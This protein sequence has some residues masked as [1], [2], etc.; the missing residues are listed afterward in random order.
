MFKQ[1][2]PEMPEKVPQDRVSQPRKR[3]PLGRLAGNGLDADRPRPQKAF[4][5]ALMARRRT[6]P[7]SDTQ[8]ATAGGET[9]PGVSL[10]TIDNR[11]TYVLRGATDSLLLQRTSCR[12]ADVHLLQTFHFCKVEAFDLWCE[13]DLLRFEEPHLWTQLLRAGH[14]LLGGSR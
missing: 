11:V 3:R 7:R 10:Q 9:P 13:S 1:G 12:R 6:R 14:D 5:A 4:T 8:T 2:S